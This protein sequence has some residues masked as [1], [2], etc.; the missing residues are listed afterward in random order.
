MT[1]LFVL[2][3]ILFVKFLKRIPRT[4]FPLTINWRQIFLQSFVLL[5]NIAVHFIICFV[6]WILT[7]AILICK[8]YKFETSSLLIGLHY[9]NLCCYPFWTVHLSMVHLL[10]VTISLLLFSGSIKLIWTC[11]YWILCVSVL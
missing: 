8:F 2:I 3:D 1:N 10:I 7:V 4:F 9:F 11:L 5:N 6:I